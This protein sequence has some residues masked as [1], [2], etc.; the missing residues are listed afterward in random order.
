M[1]TRY[2]YESP[3][4]LTLV[5]NSTTSTSQTN[6][7]FGGLQTLLKWH[8]NDPVSKEEIYRNNVIYDKYQ[9]NRNPYIDHPEYVDLAYP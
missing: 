8:Y 2:G 1:A 5:N 9:K 4:N 3:Y 6:G 7:K